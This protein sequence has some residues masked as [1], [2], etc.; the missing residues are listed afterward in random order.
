MMAPRCERLRQ[1]W[2]GEMKGDEREEESF[3]FML[4]RGMYYY[5][6][7]YMSASHLEIGFT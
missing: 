6:A 1:K 2:R 7:A 4:N 5:R 3:F